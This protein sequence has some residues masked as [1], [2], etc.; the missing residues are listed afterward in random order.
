[1]IKTS[2]FVELHVIFM[3]CFFVYV[4]LDNKELCI[5]CVFGLSVIAIYV[6]FLLGKCK[7]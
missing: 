2:L 5:V 7:I 6:M 4:C 1:M 3:Y